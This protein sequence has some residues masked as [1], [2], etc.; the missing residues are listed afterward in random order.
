MPPW[1]GQSGVKRLDQFLHMDRITAVPSDRGSSGSQETI[2]AS[3]HDNTPG[4]VDLP[5]SWQEHPL[6][7]HSAVVWG[8][9][10]QCA[11]TFS[12]CLSF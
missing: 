11:L 1:L 8:H 9:E 10:T 6:Q 12:S 3:A 7:G 4:R 2:A 5:I